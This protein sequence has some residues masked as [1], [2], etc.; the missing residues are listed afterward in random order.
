MPWQWDKVKRKV[1]GAG[2][3]RFVIW[4]MPRKRTLLYQ[5]I[6]GGGYGEILDN[7]RDTGEVD[8]EGLFDR[9]FQDAIKSAAA[10]QQG[11]WYFIF[12]L[13]KTRVIQMLQNT[14]W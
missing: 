6:N 12:L 8:T 1:Y 9:D 3:D 7:D 11:E 5:Y 2:D 14:K 13:K 10:L 4:K